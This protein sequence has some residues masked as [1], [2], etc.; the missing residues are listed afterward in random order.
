MSRIVVFATTAAVLV[1]VWLGL[2]HFAA[3]GP[4]STAFAQVFEQIQKAKTI[5]W[6]TTSYKY[7]HGKD[8]KGKGTWIKTEEECTYKAPDIYREV[9]LGEK[10][11]IEWVRI[12]DQGRDLMLY[13]KTKKADLEYTAMHYRSHG[14]NGPFNFASQEI[15]RLQWVGTRKTASGVAN[16]FRC[17]DDSTGCHW[18]LDIWIDQKTKRFVQSKFRH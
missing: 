15:N 9:R 18:S 8:G 14:A 6:K 12:T 4:G 17:T 11:Q 16:I 3:D 13:P 10:N 7:S 5:T 2:T 1:G